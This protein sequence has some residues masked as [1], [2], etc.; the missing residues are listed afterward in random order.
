[1]NFYHSSPH[2]ASVRVH[3]QEM[4]LN[5]YQ[6]DTANFMFACS[7]ALDCNSVTF[8]FL[9]RRGCFAVSETQVARALGPEITAEA[10]AA[11]KGHRDGFCRTVLEEAIWNRPYYS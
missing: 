3:K 9:L 1:M 11:C 6:I 2:S 4:E 7:F 10:A 5:S 8:Q